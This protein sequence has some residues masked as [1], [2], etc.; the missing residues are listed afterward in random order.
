MLDLL[1][2]PGLALYLILGSM[3]TAVFTAAKYSLICKSLIARVS[4]FGTVPRPGA[5]CWIGFPHPDQPCNAE[6]VRTKWQP[7]PRVCGSNSRCPGNLRSYAFIYTFGAIAL[8]MLLTSPAPAESPPSS[9]PSQSAPSAFDLDPKLIKSSPVF[10]RWLQQIPN[11]Q[12]EIQHDPTFRTRLRLGYTRYP[13]RD[14]NGWQVGLEDVFLGKTGLTLSG[15]YQASGN[16]DRTI[17]GSDLRYYLRPL[18]SRINIAPVLGYRSIETARY[19]SDGLHVGARLFLSPSR[20]GAADLSLT[21][22]WVAPG[23]D[24]E[25]GQTAIGFGYAMTRNVRLST[26]W[27]RQNSRQDQERRVGVF[28][29]WMF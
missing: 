9:P 11:V 15:D 19:T 18:G 23:T 22:S 2:F 28:L 12:Q 13:S 16:G 8:S 10:Q 17:W 14:D 27:Q 20:T 3:N 1:G 4:R 29:E 5:N 7:A 25:V 21:Q 24:A 26:E 6:F